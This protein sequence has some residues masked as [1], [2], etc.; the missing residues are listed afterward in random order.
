MNKK[1]IFSVLLVLLVGASVLGS[2][3]A[4]CKAKDVPNYIQMSEC[5]VE[6]DGYHFMAGCSSRHFF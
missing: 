4:H 3:F 5:W 1:A 6:L 2:D